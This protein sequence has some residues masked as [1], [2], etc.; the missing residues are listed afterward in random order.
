MHSRK[1]RSALTRKQRSGDALVPQR[2]TRLCSPVVSLF[3]VQ[4]A[5]L[6]ATTL[7]P[8]S[9]NG[10]RPLQIIRMDVSGVTRPEAM[11][12]GGSGGSSDG[13]M[14]PCAAMANSRAFMVKG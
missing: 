8:A 14:S 12:G 3:A 10:T 9:V 5:V 4:T 7:A 11:G 6:H 1:H 13:G 2:L